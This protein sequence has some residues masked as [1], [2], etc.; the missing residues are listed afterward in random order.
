MHL[1][2]MRSSPSDTFTR[3]G[4]CSLTRLERICIEATPV[5]SRI[6]VAAECAYQSLSDEEYDEFA[7]LF[8]MDG[9]SKLI[10][11][12]DGTPM[13]L[14]KPGEGDLDPAVFELCDHDGSVGVELVCIEPEARR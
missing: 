13:L 11:F 12:K 10:S 3:D 8:S 4:K 7:S 6:R 14:V 5:A 2:S 1:H 9:L